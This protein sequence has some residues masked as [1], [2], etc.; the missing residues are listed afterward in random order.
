M[1]YSLLCVR[2]LDNGFTDK[3]RMKG[4]KKMKMLKLFVTFL[5]AFLLTGVGVQVEAQE[6]E[7]T[8]NTRTF[9]VEIVAPTTNCDGSPLD[10]L[11][12]VEVYRI[13][14]GVSELIATISPIAPGQVEMIAQTV[15]KE[16]EDIRFESIAYDLVG[17]DSLPCGRCLTPRG[18]VRIGPACG[19][20]RVP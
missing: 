14:E 16:T 15:P 20:I 17:A 3:R 13:V 18:A 10:D 19:E 7:W 12:K 6:I 8:K 1:L 2:L 5:L 4:D 11:D 9:P